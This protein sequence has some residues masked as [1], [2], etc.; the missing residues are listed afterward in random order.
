M[1]K[2]YLIDTSGVIKYL[3]Q[4]FPESGITFLNKVLDQ[5]SIISFITEIE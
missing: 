5:E 4:T 2:R 1:A 3:N